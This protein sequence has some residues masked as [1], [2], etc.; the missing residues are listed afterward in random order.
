[1]VT[2]KKISRMKEMSAVELEFSPGTFF[3]F[4]AIVLFDN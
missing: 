2:R 4:L 3:F 1:V